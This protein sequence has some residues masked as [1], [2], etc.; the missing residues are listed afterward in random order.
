MILSGGDRFTTPRSARSRCSRV[1]RYCG[2]CTAFGVRRHRSCVRSRRLLD[3]H[4]RRAPDADG[5]ERS[6]VAASLVACAYFATGRLARDLALAAVALALA[7][8]TKLTTVFVLPVLVL[9]VLARVPLALAGARRRWH[10][11]ASPRARSGTS[12][13]SSRPASSTVAC[14]RVPADRRPRP[15]ADARPDRMAVSRLPR[16]VRRRGRGLAP[17]PLPGRASLQRS[18]SRG[19]GAFFSRGGDAAAAVAA[20]RRGERRRAV[21][22]A[23]DLGRG[24]RA[25][26]SAQGPRDGAPRPT[27]PRR[28]ACPCSSTRATSTPRTASR[29]SCCSSGLARSSSE[30]SLG[31]GFPSLPPSR[32]H[33]RCCSSSSSR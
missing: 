3:L 10:S 4:D 33:R 20:L 15:R 1:S 23:R 31:V 21:P 11:R 9:F 19:R 18:P 27:S 30:T 5:A 7:V 25:C 6:R 29:S 26:V 13:T 12:S 32:S 8:G 28:G 16:D 24:R 2:D 22:D 14:P 17:S